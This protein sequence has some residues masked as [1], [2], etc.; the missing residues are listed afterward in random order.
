MCKESKKKLGEVKKVIPN[1]LT[2]PLPYS[3]FGDENQ[4]LLLRIT[5]MKEEQGKVTKRKE[6]YP[7][8]PYSI[9][10]NRIFLEMTQVFEK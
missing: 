10:T 6:S 5:D 2:A 3:L 9:T 7:I 4:Q 8:Y 1:T